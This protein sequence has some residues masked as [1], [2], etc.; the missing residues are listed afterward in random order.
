MIIDG[1]TNDV[2]Q[3]SL[4]L[5]PKNDMR[6]EAGDYIWFWI[7]STDKSGNEIIGQGSDSAPRQV[8]LRIMEFLGSYSRSVI[9]PTMTPNVGDILTIE[10]FWENPGKRDG[11]LVV[12]LYELV[13]GTSGESHYLRLALVRWISVSYTHLTLPTICSV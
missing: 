2:Y 12:G 3:S 5:N 4:D 6:I 1:D 13:D 10:T 8:T 7:T 11:E 9:N